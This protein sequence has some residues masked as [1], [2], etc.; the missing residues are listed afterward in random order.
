MTSSSIRSVPSAGLAVVALALTATL[1]ACDGDIAPTPPEERGAIQITTETSGVDPD[2]DGYLVTVDSVST[3][4]LLTN[5]SIT[6][7]Q[8]QPGSHVLRLDGLAHNCI[9]DNGAIQ[10]VSVNAGQSVVVKFVIVCVTALGTLQ[11]TTATAGSDLDPNGYTA[12]IVS[13]SHSAILRVPISATVSLTLPVGSYNVWLQDVARNCSVAAANIGRYADVGGGVPAVVEFAVTC[14][15]LAP[16]TSKEQ[17]AFVRDGQIYLVNIDGSGLVRLTDGPED[18]APAWSPDGKRI[19]FVRPCY[20]GE[21][22][23]M[24]A[25]GS[26]IVR[27]LNLP[28]ISDPAWSPD[29]GTIAFGFGGNVYAVSAVDDGT[30]MTALVDRPSWDGQPTWSPNGTAIAFT[31]D[32]FFYDGASDI[33][34]K[35]LAD[36]QVTQLTHGFPQQRL[37]HYMPAWSPDGQT[38][39]AVV[40]PDT[41][42]TCSQSTIV[43]MNADGS[44]PRALTSANGFAK[45]TWSPDGE[46]IAYTGGGA[47]RWIRANGSEQGIVVANGHSPAWRP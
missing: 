45:P 4:V 20:G 27:R 33:F 15:P 10:R 13:A 8:V 3:H 26:N 7:Q 41:V 43:L 19:A 11:I 17:L 47:V 44:G 25:D 31:S 6:L 18:C 12:R 14:S 42:I 2:V 32:W 38:L 24:E 30:G 36:S 16:G 46:R 37:L 35:R 21:L 40:C 22:Y 23:I 34:V 28:R 5:G 39:A 29:G 1:H 9:A